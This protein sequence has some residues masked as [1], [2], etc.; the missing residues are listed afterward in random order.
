MPGGCEQYHDG[1]VP[2]DVRIEKSQ[3]EKLIDAK[4]K[5]F[6]FLASG[7]QLQNGLPMAARDV[8]CLYDS[9]SLWSH[10]ITSQSVTYSTRKQ[11]D[12]IMH[13]C[14]QHALGLWFTDTLE[15]ER[16][17][18]PEYKLIVLPGHAF[19]L[20]AQDR[21]LLSEFRS[22]GGRV[23]SLPR[24]GYKMRNNKLSPLPAVFYSA[25]DFYL[26]D[27]GALLENELEYF[28]YA[29]NKETIALEGHMWSEKIVVTN[30]KWK[31]LALFSPRSLFAGFPAAIQLKESETHGAHVHMATCPAPKKENWNALRQWLELPV[32]ARSTSTD[33]QLQT[34]TQ[35]QRVF[36]SGVH[37]GQNPATV[38]L[39]TQWKC[40]NAVAVSLETNLTARL[41]PLTPDQHNS[42][43]VAPRSAVFLEVTAK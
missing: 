3:Q 19:E 35:G 12:N 13:F 42:I 5:V 26:D 37:F 30:D 32:A 38:Q 43:A 15:A 33:L 40:L 17:R 20:S 22:K 8:L 27:H 2:H 24:T 25:E 23:L 1:V 9:E 39:A 14:H 11:I 6:S 21:Q 34:L 41:E 18:L 29:P 36:I 28:E 4:N 16:A 31:K 7:F 10:E